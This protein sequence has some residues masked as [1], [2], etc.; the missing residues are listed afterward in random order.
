MDSLAEWRRKLA[1]EH[2]QSHH[3]EWE[4]RLIKE[5]GHVSTL[6]SLTVAALA[7]S[8]TCGVALAQSTPP[9]PNPALKTQASS[10][11]STAAKVENWTKKQVRSRM[12]G[13][14]D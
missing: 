11:P 5:L 12:L 10:E 3:F 9:A 8:L 6:S 7:A 2:P 4:C 14:R 1:N 13:K